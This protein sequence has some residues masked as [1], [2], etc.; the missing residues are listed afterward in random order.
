M[1]CYLWMDK[2]S[3][4]PYFLMEEGELLNHAK[5]ESGSRARMKIFKVD[6]NK[7]LPIVEIDLVMNQALDLY[8]KG[9]IKL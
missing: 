5:L 3:Q 6:P 9:I 7:D 8:R 1:F 4:E 2:K